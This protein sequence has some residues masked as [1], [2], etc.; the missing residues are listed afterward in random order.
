MGENLP[1][2][3]PQQ[4]REMITGCWGTQVINVAAQLRIADLIGDG[5]KNADEIAEIT[6]SNPGA[7]FRLLRAMAGLGL[8]THDGGRGFALTPTGQLL[9][10]DVP[11]SMRGMALHWGTQLWGA[12]GHLADA[13]RTGEP[14]RAG[15]GG[16]EGF[17]NFAA[18]PEAGAVFNQSMADQSRLAGQSALRAY[19]F[20]RFTKIM[21]VG[22]GYG[23]LLATILQALPGKTGI[24]YDLPYLAKDATSYLQREGVGD[25][26]AFVGGD[27]F[28]SVPSGVDCY[29]IKYIIHDWN[30]ERSLT[31]LRNC[32]KAAGKGGTI[33]LVEQVVPDRVAANPL[34]SA[35]ARADMTM[36]S[37][38]G[39]MER[40][41]EEYCALFAASGMALTRIVPTDSVISLVE[42]VVVD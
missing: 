39:G 23:A 29:L 1:A 37:A 30:D 31:I 17:A 15:G 33:I 22:G 26:A 8:C 5:S 35:I 4:L 10:G 21:D 13:V 9:R 38:A 32:A 28:Q 2:A 19:D 36:L 27:F 11:G 40:T 7:L 14:K 3:S 18:N 34:H 24:V 12:Y 16:T 6:G 41:Q 25:R 20:S 42:A